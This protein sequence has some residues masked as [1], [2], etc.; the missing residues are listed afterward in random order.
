M[1]SRSEGATASGWSRAAGW[2]TRPDDIQP[3]LMAATLDRDPAGN[4]IRK[5]GVMA[6][7]LSGGEIRPG[8]AIRR[9]LPPEPHKPLQPV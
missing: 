1:P 9:E 3:G 5:A 4:L 6:I 7:V 8:D 2:T